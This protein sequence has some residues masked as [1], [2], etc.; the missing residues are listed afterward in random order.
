MRLGYNL[1]Y[2]FWARS[3]TADT[4]VMAST[5]VETQLRFGYKIFNETEK[6]FQQ[7]MKP[8]RHLPRSF[9]HPTG[10]HGLWS[11]LLLRSC[12]TMLFATVTKC[13]P[14]GIVGSL[15]I[16]GL[17]LQKRFST[18][19]IFFRLS[20][21]MKHVQRFSCRYSFSSFFIQIKSQ[22]W[23]LASSFQYIQEYN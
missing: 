18:P 2:I 6:R 14:W 10:C 16:K 22:K 19:L 21:I 15:Q 13:L 7:W 12:W 1:K 20:Y 3:Q 5:A 17:D 8:T 9:I 4:T 23:S 11:D